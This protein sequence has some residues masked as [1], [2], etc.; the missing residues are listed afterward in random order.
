VAVL[1]GSG[2]YGNLTAPREAPPRWVGGPG[3]AGEERGKPVR[4]GDGKQ[5]GE[6]GAGAVAS[7]LTDK[8]PGGADNIQGDGHLL[9]V[10]AR[11]EVTGQLGRGL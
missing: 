7:L 11:R 2:G 9:Y 3:P 8:K 10:R 5:V 4:S 1:G 6:T